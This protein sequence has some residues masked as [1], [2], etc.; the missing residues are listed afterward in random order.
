M[1]SSIGI[2]QI[3]SLKEKLEN[4]S[5]RLQDVLREVDEEMSSEEEAG[6]K[7]RVIGML[8]EVQRLDEAN[9]AMQTTLLGAEYRL[10]RMKLSLKNQVQQNKEQIVSLLKGLQLGRRHIDSIIDKLHLLSVRDRR[11]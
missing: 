7:A 6:Q 4:E 5:M 11:L 10:S 2:K 3:M 9:K 8:E 1:E